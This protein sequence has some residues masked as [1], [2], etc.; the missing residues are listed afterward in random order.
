M[1]VSKLSLVFKDGLGW[2]GRKVNKIYG[3]DKVVCFLY[4]FFFLEIYGS[5]LF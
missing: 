3:E 1:M 2:N 4:R 5:L